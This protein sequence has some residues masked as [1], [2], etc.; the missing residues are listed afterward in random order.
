[1]KRLVER[2][3][4]VWPS[5]LQP[6]L[7]TPL[8]YISNQLTRN[9]VA[10]QDESIGSVPNIFMDDAGGL[11]FLHPLRLWSGLM[12]PVILPRSD[13]EVALR[14]LSGCRTSLCKRILNRCTSYKEKTEQAWSLHQIGN[15]QMWRRS[16]NVGSRVFSH[17]LEWGGC[18]AVYIGMI[19]KVL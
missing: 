8:Q 6:F 5:H 7:V 19:V 1:M 12:C 4:A 13:V 10:F 18:I 17:S 2:L 3:I 15:E 11:Y 14:G 16:V 9:E